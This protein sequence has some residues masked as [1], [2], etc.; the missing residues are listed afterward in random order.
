MR[1]TTTNNM[2]KRPSVNNSFPFAMNGF[3]VVQH[4]ALRPTNQLQGQ[5]ICCVKARTL[6]FTRVLRLHA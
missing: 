5:D 6:T 1:I 4:N 3:S 2:A